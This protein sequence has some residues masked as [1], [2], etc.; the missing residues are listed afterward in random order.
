MVMSKDKVDTERPVS[1]LFQCSENK[2]GSL[3]D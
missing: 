3:I 2:N 1:I